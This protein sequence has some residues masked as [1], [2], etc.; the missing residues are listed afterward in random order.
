MR[1]TISIFVLL[2]AS[3]GIFASALYFQYGTVEP[4]GILRERVRQQA[5]REGGRLGAFVVTAM[6]D[7]VLDGLLAAQYG[8][9][10]PGRCINLVVHGLPEQP[11]GNERQQA[12]R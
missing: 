3:L 1:L 8:P 9:L 7:N 11:R 2:A 4:C 12:G 10:S 5:V 6:P